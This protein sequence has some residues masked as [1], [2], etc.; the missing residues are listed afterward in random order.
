[1]S[2]VIVTAMLALAVW[3]AV[4]FKY[5]GVPTGVFLVAVTG[6]VLGHPFF[7][8]DL[9]PVPLTLD[10]ALLAI[11]AIVAFVGWRRRL[12]PAPPLSRTNIIGATFVAL[13]L[14][15][16]LTHDWRA[17]SFHP[18]ATWLFFYALPFVAMLL[19][20]CTSRFRGPIWVWLLGFAGLGIYLAVMAVCETRGWNAFVWPRFI[21]DP[22][23]SEFFGRARGPLLNP[24]SNGLLLSLSVTALLLIARRLRQ[25]GVHPRLLA[26]MPLAFVPLVAVGIALTLTRSVWLG[27]VLGLGTVAATLLPRR[28]ILAGSCWA[29]V[30]AGAFLATEWEKLN[31]FK[32]DRDVS[33]AEMSESASLRPILATI[34]WKMFQD[35]PLLGFGFGQ[36]GEASQPYCAARDTNLP[37]DKGRPFVQHNVYLSLLTETGLVGLAVYLAFLASAF[38]DIRR[39]LRS[40]EASPLQRDMARLALAGL[41]AYAVNGMFHEVAIMSMVHFVLFSLMGWTSR[42]AALLVPRKAL[43]SPAAAI[44]TSAPQLASTVPC[45]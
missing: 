17:Q 16:T 28:W 37:L 7:H 29:A 43:T 32:R 26:V 30:L 18:L 40:A 12:W 20:Q 34:A 5:G 11:V 27:A 35:R 44:A 8:R 25:I 38:A 15:S 10:R 13:L 14:A 1:M 31:A 33:V 19:V 39:I 36:Y 3:L 42:L 6:I 41:V 45:H 9:G 2:L 24:I 23:F 4:L 22:R 21:V